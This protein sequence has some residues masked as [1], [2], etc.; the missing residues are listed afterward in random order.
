MGSLANMMGLDPSMEIGAMVCKSNDGTSKMGAA[1]SNMF[2][3]PNGNGP[4]EQCVVD[5]S[6]GSGK[7]KAKYVAD[8]SIANHTIYAP[9]VPPVGEK[10]PVI[11]WGNGFC[12]AAGTMFAN[13][14]NEIASH[15]YFIVANG[16]AVGNQLGGQ[17]SYK[18]LITSIDW[19]TKGDAA[20]KYGN[21]D[22]SKL[23]VAGQSCGGLE[24]VYWSP[25]KVESIN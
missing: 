25:T 16:P 23:L 12:M 2:G 18:D 19:V 10:L 14:L 8:A 7:Y 6:G 9:E 20:K 22:T 17:T 15:G 24:A 5:R 11:I 13:F 1:I 4:D 21:I 3:S